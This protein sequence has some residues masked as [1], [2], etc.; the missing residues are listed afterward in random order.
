[1]TILSTQKSPDVKLPHQMVTQVG[2]FLDSLQFTSSAL[3]TAQKFGHLWSELLRQQRQDWRMKE[4][5]F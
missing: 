2:S 4:K 1:M 5:V 3:P